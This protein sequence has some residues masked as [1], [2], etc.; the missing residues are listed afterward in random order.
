MCV[1]QLCVMDNPFEFGRELGTNELVDRQDDVAAVIETI[2]RGA[3]LFIIGPADTARA[4]SME[5]NA[6]VAV[7]RRRETLGVY[8]PTPRKPVKSASPM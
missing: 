7:T 8:V 4:P 5:S 1:I 6:P 3:K 2:R